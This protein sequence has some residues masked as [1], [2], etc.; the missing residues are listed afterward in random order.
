MDALFGLPRKKSAGTSHRAPL[1]A[2][3]F[4]QDQSAVDEFVAK[5]S[6]DTTKRNVSICVVV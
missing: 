6:S 4:F 3:L 5:C 1:H 2:D